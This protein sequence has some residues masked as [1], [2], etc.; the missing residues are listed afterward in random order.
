MVIDN[1]GVTT[2]GRDGTGHQSPVPASRLPR[3]SHHLLLYFVDVLQIQVLYCRY[4]S[5][6]SETRVYE[7]GYRVTLIASLAEMRYFKGASH[8]RWHRPWM[9][10]LPMLHIPMGG[11]ESH[12]TTPLSYQKKSVVKFISQLNGTSKLPGVMSVH[13]LDQYSP[14]S[15]LVA[16]AWKHFVTPTQYSVL[17]TIVV[18]YIYR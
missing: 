10:S 7:M 3:H 16:K 4:N 17:K 9:D 18:D 14:A 12:T 11:S 1:V 5:D 2:V 6:I 8:C 13:K 15:E